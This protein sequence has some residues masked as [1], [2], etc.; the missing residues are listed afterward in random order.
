MNKTAERI[1]EMANAALSEVGTS[2]RLSEDTCER[3][4]ISVAELKRRLHLTEPAPDGKVELL[5]NPVTRSIIVT[6]TPPNGEDWDPAP[7]S[8]TITKTY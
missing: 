3:V 4:A 1:V 8:N 6:H 7:E 5:F 2:Y